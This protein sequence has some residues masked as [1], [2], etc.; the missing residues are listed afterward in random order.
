MLPSIIKNPLA[1][2]AN[3]RKIHENSKVSNKQFQPNVEEQRKLIINQITKKLI[4]FSIKKEKIKYLHDAKLKSINFEENDNDDNGYNDNSRFMNDF[5]IDNNRN[6]NINNHHR[7]LNKLRPYT[8]SKLSA[9]NKGNNKCNSYIA[10][11]R[12]FTSSLIETVYHEDFHDEL[13]DEINILHK[14]SKA[15]FDGLFSNSTIIG[16]SGGGGGSNSCDSSVNGSVTGDNSVGGNSSQHGGGSSNNNSSSSSTDIKKTQGVGINSSSNNNK[17]I[18]GG[19]EMSC[20]AC[21]F[22]SKRNYEV[23]D[24]NCLI[25]KPIISGKRH[26]Y[27][28]H[29]HYHYYYH[30]HYQYRHRPQHRHYQSRHC[31]HHQHYIIINIIITTTSLS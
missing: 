18:I 10:T 3:L 23:I 25:T 13:F 8:T 1:E 17:I 11:R 6:N 16:G 29:H 12:P 24:I 9:L 5:S 27:H 31:Y 14:D 2:L 30:H 26:D 15:F 4:L 22:T 28:H 20:V 7:Y 19:N 21:Q